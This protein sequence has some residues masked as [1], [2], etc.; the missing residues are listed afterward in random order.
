[1]SAIEHP[2]VAKPAQELA[3]L[4]W[5]VRKLAATRDGK[6]DL[7]D[8]EAAL[9]EPTGIV[10]VIVREQPRRAWFRTVAAIA[11]AL[12]CGARLGPHRRGAGA[13][14]DRRGFPARSTCTR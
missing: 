8:L 13:G 11:E 10:S 3:R 14:Q 7:D 4:G 9:Q 12:A 2:C 6:I 5:K 1:V